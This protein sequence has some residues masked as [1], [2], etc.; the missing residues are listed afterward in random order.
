M[1]VRFSAR[2]T[3]WI[4]VRCAHSVVT[5][6]VPML[7]DNVRKKFDRPD[8]AAMREGVTPDSRIWLIGMKKNATATPCTRRGSTMWPNE[9]SRLNV[10]NHHAVRPN[11]TKASVAPARRSKRWMLRPTSGEMINAKMPT[12]AVAMPA[13]VGV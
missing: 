1:V 2:R 6:A 3:S 7:P 8:A 12:G 4:C 5:M 9:V 13:Q 11:T 10:E